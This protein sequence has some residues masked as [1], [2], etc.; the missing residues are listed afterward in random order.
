[1]ICPFSNFVTV[2]FII[3][4][5]FFTVEISRTVVCKLDNFYNDFISKITYRVIRELDIISREEEQHDN[6]DKETQTD[7]KTK[8]KKD[9]EVK[10]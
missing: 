2:I 1:M 3:I 7:G 8:D 5:F 10:Q 9:N 4:L 6:I